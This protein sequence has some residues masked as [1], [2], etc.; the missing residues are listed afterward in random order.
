MLNYREHYLCRA[1]VD[2]LFDNDAKVASYEN[3]SHAKVRVQNPYP[4]YD[5]NGQNQ[6]KSISYL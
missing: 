3:Q 4:I 5:H 2:Y 1:F 6:L